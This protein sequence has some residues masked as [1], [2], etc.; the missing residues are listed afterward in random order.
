M[1][2]YTKSGPRM[3]RW[4]E[5]RDEAQERQEQWENLTSV[6]QL[7]SLDERLGRGVGAVKQRARILKNAYKKSKKVKNKRSTN[8][9]KRKNT[10]Q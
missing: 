2:K 10:A 4:L 6:Q 9:R 1:A 8:K 5:K 3:D 7:D